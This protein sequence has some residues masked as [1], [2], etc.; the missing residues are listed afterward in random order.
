[1]AERIRREGAGRLGWQGI[2]KQEREVG[3]H[4]LIESDMTGSR[5]ADRFERRVKGC[6]RPDIVRPVEESDIGVFARSLGI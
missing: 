5:G 3:A 2:E 4:R 6:D 1:M